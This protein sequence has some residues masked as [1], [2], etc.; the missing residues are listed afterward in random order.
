MRAERS[1]RA[2]RGRAIAFAFALALAGCG[3]PG[4]PPIAPGTPCAACG[5]EIHDLHFAARLRD[6]ERWKAYDDIACLLRDARSAPAAIAYLADYDSRALHAADS[7][8]VVRGSFPSPMGGGLAAFLDRSVAET[9][10]EQTGGRAGR[11]RALLE[12]EPA[13]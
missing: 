6:G 4:P 10:A 7:M 8:W 12:A 9:V 5:M 2:P 1:G 3:A 11:W 13:P